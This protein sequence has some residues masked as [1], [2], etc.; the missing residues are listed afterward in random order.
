MKVMKD[1]VFKLINKENVRQRDELNLIPSENKVSRQVFKALG[2]CLVN[3]YAEGVAGERYYQGNKYVDQVEKLAVERAKKLFKVAHVNVQPYSGTPANS[4]VQFALL[5]EGDVMMGLM[6]SAGGHLTHGHPKITFSG[7]WFKSVQY[8]VGSDGR[9]DY[10]E[11]MAL[12][13]KEKPKLIMAGTTAYSRKLEWKKFREIADVVGAY[14]VADISHISGLVVA[15]V[16]PSPSGWVDVITTTTHK[17]LRGPRGA[18]IMVT[19]RGLRKYPDLPRRI[20]RAVFPGLQGGPHLHTIAGIAVAL[21]EAAGEDFKRYAQQVVMNAKA[22]ANELKKLGFKL[23]SGGTDN[24]LMLV[25]LRNEGV[26]GWVVA[27]AL[28]AA[29]II[30]NYNSVP[31]DE[32]SPMYPSGIR[33]GTPFLTTRGM[34]EKEMR[35]IANWIRVV[36]DW[37]KEERLPTDK[38]ER[39]RYVDE[40]KKRVMADKYLAGLQKKVVAFSRKWP[41]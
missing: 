21:K 10:S 25:D 1:M 17:T 2:S 9:L 3:K 7:K 41:A 11:I 29:G 4:A 22:L 35:Q 20:D 27:W 32:A 26:S 12:A 16:H 18:M 8:G 39:G 6:L 33:L 19:K 40:Y 13:K 37:V 15:G 28:E 30:V 34:K 31:F 23:V 24:H 5:E 36:V 14:L 38:K